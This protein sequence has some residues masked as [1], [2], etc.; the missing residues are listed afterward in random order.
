M[1]YK[2]KN[3]FIKMIINITEEKEPNISQKANGQLYS[4]L[5]QH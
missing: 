1:G 5:H 3:S 2:N 4:N